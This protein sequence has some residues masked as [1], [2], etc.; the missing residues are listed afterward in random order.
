MIKVKSL[1]ESGL[2]IKVISE[3][4]RNET[5][6]QKGGFIPMLLGTSAA[7]TF[8]DRKRSNKSSWRHN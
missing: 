8:I 7:R 2:I 6:K 5:K 3:T 1:E 4:V